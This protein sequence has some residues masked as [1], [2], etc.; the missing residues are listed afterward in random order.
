M[1]AR[2]DFPAAAAEVARPARN[3][4]AILYATDLTKNQGRRLGTLRRPLGVV[5]VSPLSYLRA[6]G[7]AETRP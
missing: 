4:A 6:C 7:H 5:A 3:R 1:M 2:P